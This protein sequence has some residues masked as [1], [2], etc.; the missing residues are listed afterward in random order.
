M[1]KTIIEKIFQKHS[2]D[3]VS[4]GE[5][6]WLDI[7]LKTARDFGGA[8]V[9]KTLKECCKANPVKDRATTYFT[10]DTNAPARDI[11]YATNQMIIRDFA[12]KENLK[13]YDVDQGIGSHIGIELGQVYPGVTVVGTDS[14][15]NIMG[16]VC[17]FGQGMGDL[18]IAYIF[19]SGRTWF[20]VPHTIKLT[21]KG[22]YSYPVT[23]KDVTLFILRHLG[24]SGAL[25]C[26]VEIYGEAVDSMKLHERITLASMATEM[27]AIT[28]LI[29]ASDEIIE[30]TKNRSGKSSIAKIEADKDAS[31]IKEIELD[32]S[33]LRPQIANPPKPDNV[34]D[35]NEVE[36][37][38]INSV[39]VGSCTNGR[40]EDIKQ[41][42]DIVKGKRIDKDVMF[43]IVPATR[44]V[45][46]EMLKLGYLSVL[47]ESGIIVSNPGCGGCASGQ[48]GMTGPN[49]VQLSTSNRNFAGKQGKGDTYL[50]SPAVAAYSALS[51]KISYPKE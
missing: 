10:F 29:P 50:V 51:G 33:G 48:I 11:G 40:I 25:G 22:G 39:F 43:K 19:K 18:D 42:V 30:F 44:E 28:I 16:A 21:L 24:A 13:V 4:A 26:A 7:D 23:A 31:Y 12:A 1:G 27:G 15:L 8:N 14:H 3:N 2:N 35:I 34:T 47:F 45:Y 9:V 20:E 6:I 37:R 36:G 32:I 5:I 41:V 17:A 46:G 38:K 49:E